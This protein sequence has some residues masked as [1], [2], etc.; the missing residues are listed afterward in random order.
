MGKSIVLKANYSRTRAQVKSIPILAT[1]VGQATLV[2]RSS[3]WELNSLPNINHTF[4]VVDVVHSDALKIFNTILGWSYM[5]AWGCSYY[6]QFFLNFQQ[7]SVSGFSVD[8]G[9][10]NVLAYFSYCVV[11]CSMYWDPT[12]R[13]IYF[14]EHPHTRIPVEIPDLASVLHNMAIISLLGLQCVFLPRGGQ[15]LTPVSYFCTVAFFVGP[16]IALPI[17]LAGG[18]SWLGFIHVYSYIKIGISLVKYGP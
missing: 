16:L 2:I 8:Y 1:A 11:M 14:E 15:R 18:I 3:S 13:A 9:L 17:K 7:W 6:P 4:I 12:I 10:L 5:F